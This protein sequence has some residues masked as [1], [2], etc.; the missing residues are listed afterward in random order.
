MYVLSAVVDKEILDEVRA[1]PSIGL[2]C[3]NRLTSLSPKSLS[4]M[5]EFS[6]MAR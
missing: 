4:C 3:T 2:M 5:L 6:V 1:S